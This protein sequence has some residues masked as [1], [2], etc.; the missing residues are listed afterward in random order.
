MARTQLLSVLGLTLLLGAFGGAGAR[1]DGPPPPPAP[2][3]P[4]VPQ[5]GDKLLAQTLKRLYLGKG[6]VAEQVI[7]FQIYVMETPPPL[8][9]IPLVPGASMLT[10][11]PE[12]RP[13]GDV[14][15]T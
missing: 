12:T 8:D 15:I 4:V 14:S 11:E 3:Q 2:G 10:R 9:V 1:A 7:L 13:G 6:L 5:T